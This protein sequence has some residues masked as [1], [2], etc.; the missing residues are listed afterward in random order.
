MPRSKT[1]TAVKSRLMRAA[2]K[3]CN[4]YDF[5]QRMLHVNHSL[6]VDRIGELY[7]EEISRIVKILE[8]L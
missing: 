8:K 3:I 5:E 7:K 1:A 2:K 6:T 4:Y